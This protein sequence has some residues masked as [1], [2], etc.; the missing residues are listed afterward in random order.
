[1]QT[2]ALG[3]LFVVCVLPL[4]AQ[5]LP[6]RSISIEQ[7]LAQSVVYAMAQDLDGF[8]WFGTQTGLSRY[9]GLEFVNYGQND[10]LRSDMIRCI[11]VGHDGRVWIGTDRGLGCIHAGKIAWFDNGLHDVSVRSLTQGPNGDI[12]IGTYGGGVARLQGERFEMFTTQQG[13][14]SNRIRA[15]LALRDGSLA[16]GTYGKGLA[17]I[18]NDKVVELGSASG[19]TNDY[20]RSFME[21]SSGALWVGT[22]EGVYVVKDRKIQPADLP[23]LAHMSIT[24]IVQDRQKRMWFA[25]RESGAYAYSAQGLRHYDANLGLANNSVYSITEDH[26]GNM[27]FGTYGGGVSQLSHE[28]FIIFDEKHGLANASVYAFVEDQDGHIWFA[29]NGGGLSVYDGTDIRSYSKKDGLIDNTVLSAELDSNGDIWLGTLNGVCIRSGDEFI[30]VE[31]TEAFRSPIV[32]DI[33]QAPDGRMWFATYDGVV[34]LNNGEFESVSALAELP[35][36]R[37][38]TI[39]FDQSGVAWLGTAGGLVRLDGEQV[40]IFGVEDGLPSEFVNDLYIDKEDHLWVATTNGCVRISDEQTF[41]QLPGLPSQFCTYVN[42]GPDLGVWVGTNRGVVKISTMQSQIYS[43]SDGLPS[44]EVNRGAGFVDSGGRVWVGTVRGVACFLKSEQRDPLP[45]PRIHLSK[46]STLD[47]QLDLSTNTRLGHNDNFLVFD[48]LGISLSHGDR[49][50]YRVKLEGLQEK[51][52]DVHAREVQYTSIRPGDYRFLVKARNAGGLWSE[53]AEF[54]FSIVPPLWQRPWFLGL[55]A[56]AIALAIAAWVMRLKRSNAILEERVI[57]RTAEV[58]KMYDE[59]Q[60]LAVTDD[61]TGLRNRR[62]L[63]LMMP[64]ELKRLNRRRVDL[65]LHEKENEDAEWSG[66]LLI[67]LDY[68]KQ[69]NDTFGHAT[70]DDV[71]QQLAELLKDTLRETDIVSRLGGEEFFVF[72]PEVGFKRIATIAEK[73]LAVIRSHDFDIPSRKPIH[74]TCSIGFAMLPFH[75]DSRRLDWHDLAMIVDAAMYR[76]KKTGRDKAAGLEVNREIPFDEAVSHLRRDPVEAIESGT[77]RSL[78]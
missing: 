2:K 15:V 8:L 58:Q 3:L 77:F 7:G 9:D 21:D 75:V 35:N 14:P 78:L 66:M 56:S 48:F 12:W 36:Q 54:S 50:W 18:Q 60:H 29:T 31:M 17:I 59:I 6:F 19:A 10:G 52:R 72:L 51:W 39:N 38:N 32:Y 40:T 34:R 68:F 26:E 43:A 44:N 42:G 23:E 49:V 74:V 13:L 1:M 53:P 22:N 55:L 46:V 57:E 67:D 41:E 5:R 24:A 69:I 25:T 62:Y 76:A 16:V 37:V 63:D 4:L 28:D 33:T 47:R 27:W 64:M 73:V 70:G 11:M 71:L 30:A 20:I 65:G 45:A 61:L